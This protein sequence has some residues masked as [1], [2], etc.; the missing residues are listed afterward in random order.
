MLTT[1][2]DFL[3]EIKESFFPLLY[4]ILIKICS[5]KEKKKMI[6][7][8]YSSI[9]KMLT[10]N[11]YFLFETKESFFSFIKDNLNKKYTL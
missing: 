11:A 4:I 1:N 3:F 9:H 8:Q 2:F 10:T 5:L 6:V 7:V